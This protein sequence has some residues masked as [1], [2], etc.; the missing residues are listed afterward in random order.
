MHIAILGQPRTGTTALYTR[1]CAALP[2]ARALFEPSCYVPEPTDCSRDLVV[3]MLIGALP[4]QE[5]A[6]WSSCLACTH[7]VLVVRDPRDT[8]LSALL[9]FPLWIARQRPEQNLAWV[10]Q[11]LK[12]KEHQGRSV[13]LWPYFVEMLRQYGGMDA[14]EASA[15]YCGQ[16]EAFLKVCE[17]LSGMHTPCVVRYEDMMESRGSFAQLEARIGCLLPAV[18]LPQAYRSILRRGTVGEWRQWFTQEDVE[19]FRP[20]MQPYLRYHNYADEW[21]LASSPRINAATSLQYVQTWLRVI[22]RERLS[23]FRPTMKE[24]R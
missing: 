2:A 3:K 10:V 19:Y 23:R 14:D 4:G 21:T 22:H 17:M 7:L 8:L 24:Q 18:P 9:F 15:W 1:F 11:W 20:L 12:H 5:P 16:L 6:Q 13:S